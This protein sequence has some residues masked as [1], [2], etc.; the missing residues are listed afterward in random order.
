MQ[1]GYN[2]SQIVSLSFLQKEPHQTA[3]RNVIKIGIKFHWYEKTKL[4]LNYLLGNTTLI[5]CCDVLLTAEFK[6]TCPYA[7]N[8]PIPFLKHTCMIIA[9]SKGN[10][11]T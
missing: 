1:S 10:T 4:R 9:S 2:C 3:W 11:S 5:F 6:Y 7:T 8:I